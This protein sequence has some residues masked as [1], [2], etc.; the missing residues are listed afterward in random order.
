[1]K[2]SPFRFIRQSLFNEGKLLRYLG[3]AI[4]EIALIIIGIMLALQ[5][6]N[7]NEDRKAQAEFEVY[8]EQLKE[9]VRTAIANAETSRGSVQRFSESAAFV[10]KFL[11]FPEYSEEQLSLFE[12]GVTR[13]GNS[14]KPQVNVGFLGQL[15]EGD[16]ETIG[17]NPKLARKALE[18]ESTIESSFDIIDRRSNHIELISANR[19]NPFRGRG[20][21]NP[22]I[23][24][25][26]DLNDLK[27]SKEFRYSVHT[28]NTSLQVIMTNDDTVIEA[29]NDFLALLEEH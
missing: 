18:L 2:Q 14:N 9:D 23:S 10:L 25:L 19:L 17:L 29:L 7:W 3:Y 13:L 5:L 28:I 22:F 12:S 21:N 15:L 4:G 27:S 26:Y 8:I 1:M 6:N 20:R 11:E 24:P 16:M